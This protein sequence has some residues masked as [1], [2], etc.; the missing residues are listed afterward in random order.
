[1]ERDDSK[2]IHPALAALESRNVPPIGKVLWL[3]VRRF[4]VVSVLEQLAELGDLIRDVLAKYLNGVFEKCRVLGLRLRNTNLDMGDSAAF[5]RERVGHQD[6][7][8]AGHWQQRRERQIVERT[9]VENL[10]DD[11]V[12]TVHAVIGRTDT[13]TSA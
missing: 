9:P 12:G 5:L 8:S 10:L 7:G 4:Q 1:L 11:G 3:I 2:E 13:A 6:L